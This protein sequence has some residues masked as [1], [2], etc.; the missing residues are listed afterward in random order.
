MTIYLFS[1]RCS[2]IKLLIHKLCGIE[3]YFMHYY[4][5]CKLCENKIQFIS[6]YFYPCK[7]H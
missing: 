1:L 5:L 2:T 7:M 3:A 4:E 6:S